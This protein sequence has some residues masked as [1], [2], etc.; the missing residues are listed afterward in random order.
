[1]KATEAEEYELNQLLSP[2]CSEPNSENVDE[3]DSVAVRSAYTANYYEN[4]I[5]FYKEQSLSNLQSLDRAI[6]KVHSEDIDVGEAERL[7][8][9]L[10]PLLDL[11]H[12]FEVV[13]WSCQLVVKFQVS[14]PD[15]LWLGSVDTTEKAASSFRDVCSQLLSQNLAPPVLTYVIDTWHK[16]VEIKKLEEQHSYPL[17]TSALQWIFSRNSPQD[18]TRSFVSFIAITYSQLPLSAK[19]RTIHDII[20]SWLKAPKSDLGS[21][22]VVLCELVLSLVAISGGVPKP[23]WEES[24]A[25]KSR[26]SLEKSAQSCRA[27][28]V[29]LA[30]LISR[31]LIDSMWSMPKSNF[32]RTE[33]QNFVSALASTLKSPYWPSAELFVSSFITTLFQL[34]GI[35][36][37]PKY[38]GFMFECFGELDDAL[39]NVSQQSAIHY[40]RLSPSPDSVKSPDAELEPLICSAI[41]SCASNTQAAY[42]ASRQCLLPNQ[43]FFDYYRALSSRSNIG[44]KGTRGLSDREWMRILG[45]YPVAT[46]YSKISQLICYLASQEDIRE[47]NQVDLLRLLEKH[48]GKNPD[49]FDISWLDRLSY[50]VPAICEAFIPLVT[51]AY[52][53]SQDT[54]LLEK[55][56]SRLSAP[57]ASQFKKR[58]LALLSTSLTLHVESQHQPTLEILAWKASL[59]SLTD[60]DRSVQ[61]AA[62]NLASSCFDRQAGP[63]VATAILAAQQTTDSFIF[64]NGLKRFL[65]RLRNSDKKGNVKVQKL[66]K[67]LLYSSKFEMALTFIQVDGGFTPYSQIPQLLAVASATSKDPLTSEDSQRMTFALA[68]LDCTMR[69]RPRVILTPALATK[70]FTICINGL[71][72]ASIGQIGLIGSI[73]GE[74]VYLADPQIQQQRLANLHKIANTTLATAL[75]HEHEKDSPV[76][77]QSVLIS[78]CA[79]YWISELSVV[80]K[81]TSQYME[82]LSQTNSEGTRLL[83]IRALFEVVVENGSLFGDPKIDSLF[84]NF[85][86]GSPEAALFTRLLLKHMSKDYTEIPSG[87]AAS[88]A[89]S[90]AHNEQQLAASSSANA[91][92]Q[93]HLTRFVALAREKED[94]VILRVVARAVEENLLVADECIPVITSLCFST[95]A[96]LSQTALRSFVT[97][98][99]RWPRNFGVKYV[100]G[101]NL[102]GSRSEFSA[103]ISLSS[104]P[105]RTTWLIFKQ[106]SKHHNIDGMLDHLAQLLSHR[107]SQAFLVQLVNG[108]MGIE[109]QIR[110]AKNLVKKAEDE[111]N[112]F[113]PEL[114]GQAEIAKTAICYVFILWMRRRY[115]FSEHARLAGRT[116]REPDEELE[117]MDCQALLRTFASKDVASSRSL[118]NE[119]W[120]LP[121]WYGS[122]KMSLLIY[123]DTERQYPTDRSSYPAKRT[124]T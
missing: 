108:L 50:A 103:S 113:D 53:E 49:L 27:S 54:N 47:S 61:Q 26:S 114:H 51:V 102:V 21:L 57:G 117:I 110:D 83:L 32:R 72:T 70:M 42:L 96:N 123:E 106:S 37:S 77:R 28:S 17:L 38:V 25:L 89:I 16:L 14:K 90:Y 98:C 15:S 30:N 31:R 97:L 73:L 92:L 87:S 65:N 4:C 55:L 40:D 86:H 59:I 122:K 116:S 76:F 22:S 60:G 23:I 41:R 58:T 93:G 33:F 6:D 9:F 7:V 29:A 69:A 24:V 1:M 18:V 20:T 67:Q 104:G 44:S 5:Q 95:Q 12:G 101:L 62:F 39:A 46:Y 56:A 91:M 63:Q 2:N 120:S 109:M 107:S 88:S 81:F 78:S 121:D 19:D 11:S 99:E 71:K 3:L 115:G 34:S 112:R 79:R 105:L 10:R 35:I 64:M 45:Q 84:K 74:L 13:L 119:L 94:L 80:R 8:Q 118:L 85:E 66:V 75:M 100:E 124:K 48:V 82:W 68:I 43:P 52:N 36:K 111:V